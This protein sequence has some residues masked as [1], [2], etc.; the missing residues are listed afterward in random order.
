MA[1]N[2]IFPDKVIRVGLRVSRLKGNIFCM[3]V[4]FFRNNIKNHSPI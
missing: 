4:T 3:I 1:S 2:G